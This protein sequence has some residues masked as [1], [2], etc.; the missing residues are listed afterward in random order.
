LRP[1]AE[2]YDGDN[3]TI[4]SVFPPRTKYPTNMPLFAKPV[5]NV[6]GPCMALIMPFKRAS[7]L[8]KAEV[9]VCETTFY[10]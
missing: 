3:S 1:L 9:T 5:N 7:F 6:F 4:C 8:I 2:C 10:E